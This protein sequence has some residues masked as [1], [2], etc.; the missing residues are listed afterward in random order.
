MTS[1]RLVLAI[2]LAFGIAAC[3]GSGALPSASGGTASSLTTTPAASAPEA[4]AGTSAAATGTPSTGTRVVI[5]NPNL[6]VTLPETWSEYPIATYRAQIV[7]ILDVAPPAVKAGYTLHLKDIDSGAVRMAA[8]GPTGLDPVTGSMI[9]QIDDGD[10]SL[11]A[12][13]ARIRRI[14][15]TVDQPTTVEERPVTL[16]IGDAIRRVETHAVPPGTSIAAIP[17]RTVE[18]IAHLADG[19]TLW[20]LASGPEASKTFEAL[21]DASVATIQTD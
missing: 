4:S 19:R 7:A 1:R 15:S 12:A 11:E 17:S 13:A 18:Y 10:A 3:Q 14:T 20:I 9:L 5:T 2:L 6:A 8:V 21:I 16:P